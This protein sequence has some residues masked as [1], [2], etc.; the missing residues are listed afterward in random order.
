[1]DPSECSYTRV[2]DGYGTRDLFEDCAWLY[3]VCREYLFSDHTEAIARA[4]FP[5]GVHSEQISMLEAGCGPGFYSRRL[6]QRYP[7]LQVLGVDQSSRLISRARART[8]FNQLK[9]CQFLE[10]DVEYLS[11]CVSAVDAVISSRLLLVVANRKRVLAEMFRV[12]KP[13]GRLFLAEPTAG[14][15]TQIPLL[16]MRFFRRFTASS[17]ER[18]SLQEAHILE[19]HEFEELV[20]SQPWATVSINMCGDYQYAL[21]EKSSSEVQAGSAGTREEETIIDKRGSSSH[22]V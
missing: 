8:S 11:D 5:Q 17:R 15:K 21:C 4:L 3:A 6:A 9:N 22:A 10:G 7:A 18:T 16:A 14:F 19:P 12:L 1:M 20:R 2:D 13:G